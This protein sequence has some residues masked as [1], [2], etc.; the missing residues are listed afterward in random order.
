M[1]PG[2]VELFLLWW[3]W[4]CPSMAALMQWVSLA[5]GRVL[6]F[7]DT[8]Q[9]Y[10]LAYATQISLEVL[11]MLAV[12]MLSPQA[13]CQISWSGES[14]LLWLVVCKVYAVIQAP[15]C[16]R[17]CFQGFSGD[18][19]DNG[20]R[21]FWG[22]GKWCQSRRSYWLPDCKSVEA[23]WNYARWH[24]CGLWLIQFVIHECSHLVLFL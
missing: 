23:W 15:G 11:L 13:W 20:A 16:S 14:S 10:C 18:V 19:V 5:E 21:S 6:L 4:P 9:A 8:L 1:K 7:N 2:F 3:A 17:A 22:R 24:F 12:S